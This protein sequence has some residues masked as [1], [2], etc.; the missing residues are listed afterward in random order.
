VSWERALAR[1]NNRGGLGKKK[2]K[3][4]TP[5]FFTPLFSPRKTKPR[6][7]KERKKRERGEKKKNVSPPPSAPL[8]SDDKERVRGGVLNVVLK[9]EPKNSFKTPRMRGDI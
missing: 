6:V 1:G 8:L 9:F 5:F 2:R 4:P 3:N 7:A